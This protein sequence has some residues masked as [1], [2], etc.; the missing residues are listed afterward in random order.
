MAKHNKKFKKQKQ[1]HLYAVYTRPTSGLGTHTDWELG[2]CKKIFHGNG[3][4]KKSG[5]TI[6]ISGKI[7]FI[8]F[9][10]IYYVYNKNRL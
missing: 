6:L 7:D 9:L 1:T 4:E 3:N 5:V 2:D 8:F 10:F